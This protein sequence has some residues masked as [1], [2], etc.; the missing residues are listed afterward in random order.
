MTRIALGFS[1]NL[2]GGRQGLIE[3]ALWLRGDDTRLVHA[4]LAFDGFVVDRTFEGVQ[5]MPYASQ[6]EMLFCSSKNLFVA[7]VDIDR[8]GLLEHFLTHASIIDPMKLLT[9]FRYW[10]R[11]PID[12]D[13]TCFSY[14]HGVLG[15]RQHVHVEPAD[16][17]YQFFNFVDETGGDVY[18]AATTLP[19]GK[20]REAGLAPS[21]AYR[22]TEGYYVPKD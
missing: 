9:P 13:T 11:L 7:E 22:I 16:L 2:D 4:F 14:L 6:R 1:P 18:L 19:Y 12:D 17:I 10:F 15:G 5:V 8:D 3:H 20:L 21:Q